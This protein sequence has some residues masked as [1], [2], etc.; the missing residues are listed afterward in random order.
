MTY[1]TKVCS[2]LAGSPVIAQTA[3]SGSEREQN[4]FYGEFD[5]YKLEDPY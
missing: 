1:N 3:F 2:Y 4:I 5:K